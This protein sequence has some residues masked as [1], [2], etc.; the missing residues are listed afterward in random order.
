[1]FWENQFPSNIIRTKYNTFT[2]L[3]VKMKNF[4]HVKKTNS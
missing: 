3:N 1:M 2:V 4:V